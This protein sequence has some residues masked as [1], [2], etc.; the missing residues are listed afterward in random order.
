MSRLNL[1]G[2]GE[3][4]GMLVATAR[5]WRKAYR[6]RSPDRPSTVRRTVIV[7]PRPIACG[8]TRRYCR[9]RPPSRIP[10]L[11]R[12]PFLL[13]ATPDSASVSVSAAAPLRIHLSSHRLRQA[14]P[15]LPT[16][17]LRRPRLGRTSMCADVCP[18]RRAYLAC[19]APLPSALASTSASAQPAATPLPSPGSAGMGRIRFMSMPTSVEVAMPGSA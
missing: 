16:P 12:A 14:G 6:D 18:R 19:D 9:P 8:E 2:G 5:A 3:A 7:A 10:A 15:P 13:L 11:L 1:C 4:R 17:G